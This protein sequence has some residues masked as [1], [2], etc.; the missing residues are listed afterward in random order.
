MNERVTRLREATLAARP[1]VSIERAALLTEFYRH[2]A[3]TSVPMRRARALEYLLANQSIYLGKDELIVGE[4]GPEPKATPTF[5]EL[6]CH[7]LEDFEVLNSREKIPYAVDDHARRV[8][9][10]EVIPY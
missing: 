2:D 1:R 5:P 3:T 4:R 8:E 6:C 9:E 10:T 7:S